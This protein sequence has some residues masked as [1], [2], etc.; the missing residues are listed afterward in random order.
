LLDYEAA[1][2]NLESLIAWER[3][4]S[5]RMDRNE[6]QTRR[7][8]IDRLLEECLAWPPEHVAVETSHDGTYTDY[9][10]GSSA[11]VLVVEAKREGIAFELPAGFNQATLPIRQLSAESPDVGRAMTQALSYAQ[12]RSIPVAAVANGHQLVA[13]LGSR[14]DGVPSDLGR[15]LVFPS[16]EAIRDRFRQFWDCLSRPG[17]EARHIHRLLTADRVEPPPEKLSRRLVSYPGYKNR[18]P[19]AAELQILGGMFLEDIIRQPEIEPDFLRE[20]YTPSGSLSQYALVSKEILAARYSSLLEAETETTLQPVRSKAGVSATLV[21]DVFAA[22]LGRRPIILLG[23][24]GVGKTMFTR[25]FIKIEARDILANSI[26]LYIDFGNKP[27]L[28]RDLQSYVSAEFERQLDD[29]YALDIGDRGFVRSVYRSE[30]QH[31]ERSIFG[32]LKETDPEAYALREMDRLAEL[33]AD[34]E[35]HLKRSLEHLARAQKRQTVVFLDNVDQ[36]PFEFQEEVFLIAQSLAADWPVACFIALRPET[37]HR[38][39]REGSLTGYQSRV[40]TIEPPRVDR[41]INRRLRFAS[42]ELE[43]TGRLPTFPLGLTITTPRLESYLEVLTQ[44]F[45]ENRSLMEFVDNMSGGNV[46][47]ALEFVVSFVGSG[48]VDTVKIFD[49]IDSGGY[50]LPVHEFFRAVMY[51]EHEY[52]YPEDSPI[53]NVFDISRPDPREHFLTPI[54]VGFVERSGGVGSSPGYAATSSV[55]DFGQSIGFDPSQ[56]ASA[57]DRCVAKYLL[58]SPPRFVQEVDQGSE[59][60]R[61]RVTTVGAFTAKRLVSEFQYLDAM[62]V[63]TPI[64]SR[65]FR[66]R[67]LEGFG[68]GE[69]IERAQAFREYLDDCWAPFQGRELPFDWEVCS[70]AATAQLKEIRLATRPRDLRPEGR[71]SRVTRPR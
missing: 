70:A 34:H 66:G 60:D 18:N 61:C 57:L 37:F 5:A 43:E 3:D 26:V 53:A 4:Q 21:S 68:I 44:A 20:C 62:S 42:K 51:G 58:E 1:K 33:I 27:A 9:E 48:H 67:I 15:A 32:S 29:E 55:Y 12:N 39:R 50:N 38:S 25:N 28:S 56:I 19:V 11:R 23:D 64:V 6:A 10:L 49:A 7:D 14:V 22:G 45:D 65:E 35:Q 2:A 71:R 63:D 36:R 40:F 54:V 31:Y 16:L 8:L 47:R 59:S 30:L 46:R 17:L 69:R 13:F 52:F 24:V 41:V